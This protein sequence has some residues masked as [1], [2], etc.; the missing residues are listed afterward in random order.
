MQN[1]EESE[2]LSVLMSLL[3]VLENLFF[4]MKIPS[5]IVSK[6]NLLKESA[7]NQLNLPFSPID[8]NRIQNL[9]STTKSKWRLF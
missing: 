4:S 3:N 7:F 2:D 1:L 5:E 6:Y 8:D 9:V